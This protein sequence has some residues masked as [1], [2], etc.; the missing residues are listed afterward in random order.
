MPTLKEVFEGT[1]LK[2]GGVNIFSGKSSQKEASKVATAAIE[3]RIFN[4][5]PRFFESN[6]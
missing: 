1:G 5:K 2:V 3:I 6:S 4:R